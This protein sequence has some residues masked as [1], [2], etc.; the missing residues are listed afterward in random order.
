MPE[1]QVDRTP[2]RVEGGPEGARVEAARTGWVRVVRG[3]TRVVRENPDGSGWHW[4][5]EDG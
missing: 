5:E 3:R 4:A 2:R 1:A